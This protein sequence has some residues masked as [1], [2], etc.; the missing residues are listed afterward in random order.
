MTIWEK[1][2]CYTYDRKETNA[3]SILKAIT[4]QKE[5]CQIRAETMKK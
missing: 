5:N 3:L 4:K 2:I 1:N